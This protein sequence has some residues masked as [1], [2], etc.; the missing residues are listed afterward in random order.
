MQEVHSDWIQ[1]VKSKKCQWGQRYIFHQR[2]RNQN[3]VQLSLL[4]ETLAGWYRKKPAGVYQRRGTRQ[5]NSHFPTAVEVDGRRVQSLPMNF[6]GEDFQPVVP[7]VGS[8]E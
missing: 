4:N 7:N 3:Q 5:D 6:L 2:S 1:N 8:N